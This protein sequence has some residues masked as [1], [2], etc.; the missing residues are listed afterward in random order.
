MCDTLQSIGLYSIVDYIHHCFLPPTLFF[1]N[2]IVVTT[3]H[4]LEIVTVFT[5][6]PG[7]PQRAPETRPSFYVWVMMFV[8]TGIYAISPHTLPL[9][10]RHICVCFSSPVPRLGIP[11]APT[12]ATYRLSTRRL[13]SVMMYCWR[14]W[15]STLRYHRRGGDSTLPPN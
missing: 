9:T 1:T 12:T 14:T 11:F 7:V 6:G 8:S 13:L 4:P 3:R 15:S 10:S 5:T 2:N